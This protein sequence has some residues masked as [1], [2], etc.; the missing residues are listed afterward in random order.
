MKKLLSFLLVLIM[1]LSVLQVSAEET[2]KITVGSG[3]QFEKLTD[4]FEEADEKQ[5][6]AQ[7]D[8]DCQRVQETPH[9]SRFAVS[10]ADEKGRQHKRRFNTDNLGEEFAHHLK[11]H[12]L[13][14][15]K[16]SLS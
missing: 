9:G 6:A 16:M 4:A 15:S 14:Q 13:P 10:Y 12:R 5:Y 3:K 8:H 11:I 1:V 2:V 7:K